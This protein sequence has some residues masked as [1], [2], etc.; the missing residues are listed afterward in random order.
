MTILPFSNGALRRRNKICYSGQGKVI[1]LACERRKGWKGAGQGRAGK[2][3][4]RGEERKSARGKH[5]LDDGYGGK[6]REGKRSRQEERGNGRGRKRTRKSVNEWM[7]SCNATCVLCQSLGRGGIRPTNCLGWF[8]PKGCF[9]RSHPP[10]R[11]CHVRM[12][13]VLSLHLL[14]F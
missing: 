10:I 7:C 1:L 6:G 9:I 2:G 13:C 8:G 5:S 4:G 14:H 3:K 11:A 12:C